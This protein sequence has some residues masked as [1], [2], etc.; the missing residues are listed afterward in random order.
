MNDN[1]SPTKSWFTT[2]QNK[3]FHGLN[4]MGITGKCYNTFIMVIGMII[5]SCSI[6]SCSKDDDDP[7]EKGSELNVVVDN[8]GVANGDH[9]FTR[10]DDKNFIIDDIKYTVVDSVLEVTG[11]DETFF[12]GEAKIINSLNYHG[13][14]L[15]VRCIGVNAFNACKTL[16]AIFI[17]QNVTTIKESAFK[18]C[19]ALK[20]I[21]IISE[22]LTSIGDFA[23]YGCSSINSFTIPNSV[24]T[25]GKRSFGE[26]GGLTAVTISN[27]L[28][29][30]AQEAFVGCSSLNAIVI[31]QG[32]E[33]IGGSAFERCRSLASINIPNRVT[34]INSNTFE[35]CTGLT[36][37]TIPSGM[38]LI[39]SC[40][41]YGCI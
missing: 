35:Y 15:D 30:L 21:T 18:N 36:A 41:F 19:D 38:K 27:S 5:A 14:Q 33:I 16:T 1:N 40:A 25:I 29:S 4:H 20:T 32:V 8:N 34:L 3:L 12:K 23:F 6:S 31:P 39:G 24:V 7:T 2:K 10:I 22:G 37:V 9:S 17:P 13:T 26:C 11:Y 28:T